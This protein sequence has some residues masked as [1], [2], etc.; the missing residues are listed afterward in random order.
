[1]NYLDRMR[2]SETEHSL[3]ILSQSNIVKDLN[4]MPQTILKPEEMV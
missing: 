4:M 1:M 3:V 2:I